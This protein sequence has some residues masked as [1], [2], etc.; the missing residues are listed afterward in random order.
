M[1]YGVIVYTNTQN[2][3]DDI[4]SYAASRLL[5]KVDYYIDRE[6]MDVFR[7]NEDEPVNT[8]MNGWFM[9]NKLAWPVSPCIN[10]LYI[11]MHFWKDDALGIGSSFLDDFGKEDLC[12]HGPVGCRDRETQQMLEEKGIPTWFSGCVTLTLKPVYPKTEGGYICL[13]N[14]SKQLEEWVRVQ[15]PEEEIRIIDQGASDIV[16]TKA[17]WSKRFENV[18]KLL[19]LYQ[20]AKAVIT[21]RL[22]CAMPCLALETPVLLVQRDDIEEQGRFDGLKRFVRCAA[23]SDLISGKAEFDLYTPT[24]NTD[25]FRSCVKQIENRVQMFI[26]EN[27]IC[28]A[29]LSAR[30][31]KYDAEWVKRVMWKNKQ[32]DQLRIETAKKWEK[33]AQWL[34]ELQAGKDWNER[35]AQELQE[36]NEQSEKKIEELEKV[37]QEKHRTFE[38][39]ID[40]KEKQIEEVQKANDWNAQ[41]VVELENMLQEQ[42]QTFETELSNKE[43]RIEEVQKANDWNAR[44]VSELENTLQE[45]HQMFETELGEK[46]NRIEEVQKANDWNAR[47]VSELENMLQEQHQTFETELGKKEKR[48]EEVQRANDWNARK[49]SELENTLQEQHQM[50]ETE[51]GKKEKRIE[52]VQRA[53]DWNAQKV[54]ELENLVRTFE[55]KWSYK[56][57]MKM[58]NIISAF[59]KF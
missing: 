42:H 30:F 37:I 16:E 40:E 20:N 15:Y 54:A 48:I 22:H 31:A 21:T 34:D 38:I 35:K 28:T 56:L 7:P 49:V 19:I 51:L 50:F 27:Q 10:P 8:I 46:E 12:I 36:A 53:N 6:Q 59:K 24:P 17:N 43:K 25:D 18:E 44:K 33:N 52:E 23:E 2:I 45:Q 32:L 47:K 39:E 9:Y 14:V 3:G 1:K 11:S 4:Q 41:K 29:E 57:E 58:K 55:N 5:P 13:V 26:Q